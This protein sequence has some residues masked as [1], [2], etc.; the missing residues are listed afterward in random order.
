M[1]II[2]LRNLSMLIGILLTIQLSAQVTIGSNQKPLAGALLDLKE[3]GGDTKK[4]LGLPKVK[5]KSLT[6]LTM[7]DNVIAD[8]GTVWQDHT[9]LLVY[10]TGGC[11]DPGLYT[12]DGN[13]WQVIHRHDSN[14][15]LFQPNSYWVEPG[16]TML[17]I[18]IE[19]AFRIWEYYGGNEGNNRL[20]TETVTGTLTPLLYWQDELIIPSSASLSISGN[21]RDDKITVNLVGGTSKGNAVIALRDGSGTI[22]WSW[23]IWVTDDPTTG[24]LNGNDFVW[25]DRYLGATSNQVG[26]VAT[27]GLTYQWGRKDP[28][29][30]PKVWGF[31][32]PI[33][34]SGHGEQATEIDRMTLSVN[35]NRSINFKNSINFPI[36]FITSS[37]GHYDWY[38][39]TESTSKDRWDW[40]LD[41]TE[42]GCFRKT[43]I[44]PCPAGWRVP[45]WE[46][47]SNGEV[48]PNT[49]PWE[50]LTVANGGVWNYAYTWAGFG[51]YSASGS[52]NSNGTL[53]LI[54][55]GAMVSSAS[56]MGESSYFLSFHSSAVYPALLSDRASGFLVRCVQ[57]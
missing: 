17:E 36:N 14:D 22:R 5:L 46:Y 7:G 34:Q 41:R 28:F 20:P 31:V 3:D 12:W 35:N 45:A 38:S 9:G 21:N 23:H 53:A 37:I 15:A 44:D 18:P 52:R 4:G 11:I 55:I 39:T 24:N 33:L 19:K 16:T 2:I 30:M 56:S 43:P 47:D 25:M 49:T 51:L 13:Q 26:D 40:R 32:E 50:G 27:I 42:D 10:N 8:V 54:G 29:P 57:E 1:K 6:E 48:K